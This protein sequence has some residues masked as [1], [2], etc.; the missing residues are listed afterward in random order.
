MQYSN[1]PDAS[2][3]CAIGKK[4]SDKVFIQSCAQ[5]LSQTPLTHWLCHCVSVR[6]VDAFACG[7]SEV[8][9]FQVLVQPCRVQLYVFHHYAQTRTSCAVYS[10]VYRAEHP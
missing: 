3:E 5:L 6:K 7:P 8:F 10:Q 9:G 4:V 1:G 2:T